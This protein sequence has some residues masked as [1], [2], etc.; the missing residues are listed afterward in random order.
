MVFRDGESVRTLDVPLPKTEDEIAGARSGLQTSRYPRDST[1]R[2]S[3]ASQRLGANPKDFAPIL[4]PKEPPRS[5]TRQARVQHGALLS[6]AEVARSLSVCEAT[7]YKLCTR[8]ILAHIRIL[9]AVR[10]APE[11]LESYLGIRRRG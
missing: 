4:L 7:V 3:S 6:V 9:N 1:K 11:A 5:K 2:P 10:V 8:G